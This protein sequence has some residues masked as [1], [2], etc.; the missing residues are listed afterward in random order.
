[1]GHLMGDEDLEVEVPVPDH[2]GGV[3]DDP[4]AED[5]AALVR[6]DR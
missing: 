4:V 3:D 2:V 6:L 5:P 1:M